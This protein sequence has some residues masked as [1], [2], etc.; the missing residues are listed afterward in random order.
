M[1]D[2]WKDPDVLFIWRGLH[3]IHINARSF[4]PKLEE[5]KLFVVTS[6]TAVIAVSETWLHSSVQDAEIELTSYSVY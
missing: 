5:I 2:T 1:F 4:L 6:K 3:F